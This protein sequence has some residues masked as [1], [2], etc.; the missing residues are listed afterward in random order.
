MRA[1]ETDKA[2]SFVDDRLFELVERFVK[3]ADSEGR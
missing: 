1:G 2:V 3:K